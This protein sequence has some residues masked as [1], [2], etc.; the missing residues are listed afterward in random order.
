M[1]LWE[2]VIQGLENTL[3]VTVDEILYHTR[4]VRRGA[5]RPFLVADMPYRS[6]QVSLEEAVRNATRFIAEGGAEAVKLEGGA[7]F[8]DVV[9]ALVR[10]SVP[11]MGHLGL[12]PQS[13]HQFGGYRIQGKDRVGGP[14]AGG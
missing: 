12:T 5:P 10:A 9:R 2:W 3:P 11:V 4:A 6:Y 7:A 13:V 1:I 14:A 8:C